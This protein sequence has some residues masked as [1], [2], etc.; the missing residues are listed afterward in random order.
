MQTQDAIQPEAQQPAIQEAATTETPAVTV[1]RAT[2]V[3]ERPVLREFG[4]PSAKSKAMTINRLTK[5][6]VFVGSLAIVGIGA[7][8]AF[9]LMTAKKAPEFKAVATEFKVAPIPAV[10]ASAPVIAA[11]SPVDIADLDVNAFPVPKTLEEA[12]AQIAQ[13]KEKVALLDKNLGEAKEQITDMEQEVEQVKAKAK[14]KAAPKPKHVVADEYVSVSV[15][16]INADRVL[17]SDASQPNTKIT[18]TAGAQLPGGATFIGFDS[19]SRMMKTDQGDFPI[20]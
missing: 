8:L 5:K 19:E 16:D 4:S 17:V 20:P 18:V 7:S 12:H 2:V 10:V 3:E 1:T 9:P 11:S 14:A 15:L 13:M 6:M